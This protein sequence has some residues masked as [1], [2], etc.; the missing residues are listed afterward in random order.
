[1][2]RQAFQLT[3]VESKRLNQRGNVLV[4]LGLD[5]FINL[6]QVQC[7]S[8]GSSRSLGRCIQLIGCCTEGLITDRRSLLLLTED[9]ITALNES[10]KQWL[11]CLDSSRHSRL[12]AT[13]HVACTK[14]SHRRTLHRTSSGHTKHGT[15]GTLLAGTLGQIQVLISI[16]LDANV[17][18]QLACRRLDGLFDG[19]VDKRSPSSSTDRRCA[20]RLLHA[21][22]QH[23]GDTCNRSL[24][25][26]SL[27]PCLVRQSHLGLLTSL[28]RRSATDL[29][30]DQHLPV[31]GGA[32]HQLVMAHAHDLV[33]CAGVDSTAF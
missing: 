19:L 33:D 12:G 22:G 31:L 10:P 2:L 9:A 23:A 8:H 26:S 4:T 7:L 20:E 25:G 3:R 1:M 11:A 18:G 14:G 30:V 17:L 29:Q 6:G 28:D 24:D 16:G 32:L 13:I 15:H 5:G 27:F 21:T